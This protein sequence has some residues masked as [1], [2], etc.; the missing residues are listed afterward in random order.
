MGN[1]R[2]R[3]VRGESLFGGRVDD[4]AYPG[5][6]HVAGDGGFIP[7]GALHPLRASGNPNIEDVEDL[8]VDA[9]F[10]PNGSDPLTIDLDANATKE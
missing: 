1:P 3:T 9:D 8:P 4:A 7:T 6:D 10:H 5:Q 2:A